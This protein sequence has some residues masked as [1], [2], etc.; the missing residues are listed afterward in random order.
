MTSDRLFKECV[1]RAAKH[2]A[3]KNT[4]P[5]HFY[6]FGYRG[7]YTLSNQLTRA[8]HSDGLGKERIQLKKKKK[9]KT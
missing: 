5:V 4:S 2:L 1:A 6:E 8:G 3:S 7:K 9:R